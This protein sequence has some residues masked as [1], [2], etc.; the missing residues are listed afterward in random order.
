MSKI[1]KETASN[2]KPIAN[3]EALKC[4]G[5]LSAAAPVVVANDNEVPLSSELLRS[6]S[7]ISTYLYG[8]P[9]FRRRVYH[10]VSTSRLPVFRLGSLICARRS[11]LDRFIVAQEERLNNKDDSKR[12]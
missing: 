10:L 2:S 3:I 4:E 12:K 9:D 1:S 7:A 6:A 8:S 5:I 11:T